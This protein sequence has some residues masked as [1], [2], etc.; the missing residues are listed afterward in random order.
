MK[1]LMILFMLMAVNSST[2]LA[3]TNFYTNVT[4]LWYQGYKTNVL[5]IANARLAANS[6]DI[7]GLILKSEY[8]LAFCED[9]AISNAYSRVMQVGDMIAT[10]N[11]VK[12]WQEEGGKQDYL[13]VLDYMAENPLT[14]QQI[15]EERVKGFINEKPLADAYLIEALQKDGYF[16]Q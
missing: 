14:P 12:C 8:H 10:T 16:D 5:A 3:Q 7:A 15:Q 6:N 9:A 11:F 4:N 1:K 13:D 2:G